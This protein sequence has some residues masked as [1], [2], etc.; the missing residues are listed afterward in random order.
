MPFF[1]CHYYGSKASTKLVAIQFHHV[2]D[3]SKIAFTLL[4]QFLKNEGVEMIDC[5]MNTK[6][7]ASLGAHEISRTEFMNKMNKLIESDD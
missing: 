1:V 4:V 7:L 5:Q 3:A 2:T 6:H